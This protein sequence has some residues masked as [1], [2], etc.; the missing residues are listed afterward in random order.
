MNPD[1]PV[2]DNES[3]PL[4]LRRDVSQKPQ[5]KTCPSCGAVV[6][7]DSILCIQCGYN[8]LTKQAFQKPGWFQENQKTV[9][10]AGGGLALVLIF[11]A[12]AWWLNRPAPSELPPRAAEEVADVDHRSEPAVV[13]PEPIPEA[14]PEPVAVE[15][16]EN[17]TVPEDVVDAPGIEIES[18]EAEVVEEPLPPP[19]PTPEEI[20]AQE[21]E[22]ARV[23]LEAQKSQARDT[24]SQQLDAREPM[25]QKGDEI[26][27]LKRNGLVERGVFQAVFVG[28][29][30]RLV[31]ITNSLGKL[32]IP[33]NEIKPE[34]LRRLDKDFRE[35]WIH[36]MTER[37]FSEKE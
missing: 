1:F 22:A 5:D 36:L 29:G 13:E 35:R 7:S 33:L 28:E 15:E 34:T 24:L 26:E 31:R 17:P 27:I 16:Q 23:A 6:D 20:A 30:G 12:F 32:D 8:F 4:G 25:W 10:L 37:R 18:G 14:A 21:A 2:S 3:S 9:K 11:G 19:G